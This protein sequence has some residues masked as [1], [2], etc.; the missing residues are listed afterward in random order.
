MNIMHED[1]NSLDD[2]QCNMTMSNVVKIISA[3]YCELYTLFINALCTHY[4]PIAPLL[5]AIVSW[6]PNKEQ[7]SLYQACIHVAVDWNYYIH[8]GEWISGAT[9][10]YIA[11]YLA[12]NY[13]KNEQV[14][15]TV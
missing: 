1:I 14:H 2:I 15:I 13:G 8:A 7:K 6:A 4:W 9:C 10:M 12:D 5:L 3:K 11:S